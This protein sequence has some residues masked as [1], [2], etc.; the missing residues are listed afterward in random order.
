MPS[1][2]EKAR[3]VTV[4]RNLGAERAAKILGGA[5][6]EG[7]G[8]KCR[9]P[10][11]DD[12]SPSLHISDRDD[13]GLLAKCFGGCDQSMLLP[14]ML[15]AGV[16][17]APPGAVAPQRCRVRPASGSSRESVSDGWVPIMPVPDDARAPP[18]NGASATW[19]YRDADGRPLFYVARHEPRT[20]VERKRFC[21]WIFCENAGGR[22]KWCPKAPPAPR[23]LYGL[24][25]LAACPDASVLVT[26]G[27]KA[28]DA[29]RKILPDFVVVTSPN[30]SEAAGRADWSPL[31]G[32]HVTVWPDADE[33]GGKF[34]AEV[35]DLVTTA[36]ASSVRI[37]SIPSSWPNGWDLAD[38]LP[39]G[40]THQTL[41]QMISAAACRPAQEADEPLPLV[42]LMPPPD[43]Y[44]VDGLGG[45]LAPVV[46]ALHD[47]VQSPT[48]MCANAVLAAVTLA[49]QAHI[50][51]ELPIGRGARRPVPN[52]FVTVGLSGERK[53]ATDEQV[54]QSIKAREKD[55][56]LA[57]E[58]RSPHLSRC[59]RH[60][61]GRA[62]E[63]SF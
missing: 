17:V 20:A 40:V 58:L 4:P 30:G 1:R 31:A 2:S 56:A 42:R 60:L 10:A 43:Q 59:A 53:S 8:W 9:C 25:L 5:R 29:A 57:E 34:A 35:A 61:G 48:A 11:H 12:R 33:A 49:A 39:E 6:R 13:G 7:S 38:E 28:A 16:D 15:A 3:Q 63:D 45:K 14:A 32:R 55:L 50:D 44:P 54:M 21:P 41:E 22:R 46:R 51:V 62:K 47:I 26:E 36:G 19:C 27:E 23:P 52:Y 37:V 18:L 24:E